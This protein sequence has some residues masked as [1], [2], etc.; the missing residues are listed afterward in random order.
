MDGTTGL[1]DGSAP[2]PNGQ[3]QRAADLEQLARRV[4]LSLE[5][6][7]ATQPMRRFARSVREAAQGARMERVLE[8]A[9]SLTG[10]DLGNVQIRHPDGGLRI[11]CQHGFG[12]E[13][14]EYFAV[15]DDEG[16]ACGR[17][18]AQRSQVVIVD[19]D[20]DP[21]FA[22]HRE[23]AA[24]SG[25]R[26]VQST[27]LVDADGRLVGIVS[28]H[29][30]RPHRPSRRDLLIMEWYGDLVAALIGECVAPSNGED[31]SYA[32]NARR[33]VS[34]AENACV[35]A[36]LLHAEAATTHAQAAE[37]HDRAVDLCLRL[38]DQARRRGNTRR[39]DEL[40]ASATSNRERA[41]AQRV[42]ADEAR[43]RSDGC[44]AA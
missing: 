22:P 2:A 29:F 24:A 18:A 9:L 3:R 13:F 20:A 35:Y 36:R 41:D 30:R 43:R 12:R 39:A 42:R 8:G 10:A 25:F 5:E 23:I 6:P 1:I 14:L 37:I 28:T 16:A 11:A 44:G 4:R 15:V 21:R 40:E 19:V 31:S 33:H 34:A 17:A 32:A 7:Q 26:A 27:P 38:A